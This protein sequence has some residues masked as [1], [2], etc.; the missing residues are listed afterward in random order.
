[1]APNASAGFYVWATRRSWLV[2]I[3]KGGSPAIF[4]NKFDI[5]SKSRAEN[6]V[7]AV[8][9]FLHANSGKDFPIPHRHYK[10]LEI[11][12]VVPITLGRRRYFSDQYNLL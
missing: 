2:E 8:N 3:W 10:G 5:A 9:S 1:M 12:I 4:S 6:A 11:A 7:P